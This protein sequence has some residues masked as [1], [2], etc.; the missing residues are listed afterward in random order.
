LRRV[1]PWSYWNSTFL[2]ISSG[3]KTTAYYL[4][5]YLWDILNYQL[6]LWMMIMLLFAFDIKAYTT[7]DR[8]V[9]GGVIITLLLFGP[10]GAGFTYCCTFFLDS[11][12]MCSLFVILFNFIIGKFFHSLPLLHQIRL[13]IS[14]FIAFYICTNL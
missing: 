11:S 14:Y 2:C 5:T 1:L 10:A 7:T 12:S 9:I 6:P 8:G 3:V 4:S 13:L